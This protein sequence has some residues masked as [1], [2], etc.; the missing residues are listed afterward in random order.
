MLTVLCV[1]RPSA[2]YSDEYVW[3]LKEAVARNLS[4]EHR[5][6]C[7]CDEPVEGVE[8]E[9]LVSD[10]PGWWAKAEMFRPDLEKYGRLL[11]ID[12]DTVIAGSLDDIASYSG[13]AAVTKDFYYGGPSQSLL[14]YEVGAFRHVW[15]EFCRDP[16][17]WMT[18]GDKMVAPHFGDQVLLTKIAHP[19]VFDYWQ[20][21]LPG[22][23]VS[24]RKHCRKTKVLDLL[25]N[26]AR[27]I[28]FHGNPKPRDFKAGHWVRRLWEMPN[29]A[30]EA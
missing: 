22:Q 4:F 29:G 28:S 7:L 6:V 16:Q 30:S 18:D 20:D 19:F 10:W 24:Y 27:V 5:F 8:C 11:Y 21:I 13:I 14:S 15:R 9:L 26:D 25:P 2:A 12:L 3:N 17:L 23:L 1:Y